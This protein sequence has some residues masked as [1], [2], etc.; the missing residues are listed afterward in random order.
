[1]LTFWIIKYFFIGQRFKHFF[2]KKNNIN[3]DVVTFLMILHKKDFYQV[4]GQLPPNI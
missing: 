1:M 4:L 3:L 2:E